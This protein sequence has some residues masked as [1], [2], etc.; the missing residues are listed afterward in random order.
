MAR[1]RPNSG[2]CVRLVS[3]GLR[4]AHQTRSTSEKPWNGSSPSAQEI[5]GVSDWRLRLLSILP[6]PPLKKQGHEICSYDESLLFKAI[7]GSL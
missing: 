1:A 4:R 3:L 2:Q 5:A 7:M 6:S